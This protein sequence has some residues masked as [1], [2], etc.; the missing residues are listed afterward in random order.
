[1]IGDPAFVFPGLMSLRLPLY[2]LLLVQMSNIP[3]KPVLEIWVVLGKQRGKFLL[4]YST[5][6]TLKSVPTLPR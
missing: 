2:R 4:G 3:D 5:H 6:N 1:M